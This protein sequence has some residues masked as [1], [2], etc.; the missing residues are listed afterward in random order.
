MTSS[1]NRVSVGVEGFDEI[2]DGG[3]FAEQSYLVRGS[4]GA[5]K[6]TFGLHFLSEGVTRDEDVLYIN[7][8]EG[9]ATIE[10]A[11][12]NF[13]FP[14]EEIDILD[15]A[16]TGDEFV[17]EEGYDIF[18][19]AEVERKPLTDEIAEAVSGA[20]P[21]RVFVDPVTQL[22]YLTP[23]EYQFRK[24][25]LSLLRFL[26][27][28]GATVLFTSQSTATEPDDDLQFM[29]DG[30][31][32]LDQDGQQRS[33]E[34][35]KF[36]GSDYAAGTHSMAIAGDGI[37]VYPVLPLTQRESCLETDVDQLSAGIP[38][39]D[40][41]LGG[42]IERGTTT[43]IS[44]PTGVGKSTLGTVFMKEAAGQGE[45]SKLYLFE[46]SVG[47]VVRRSQAVNIP[48][49]E[50]RDRGTLDIE[51]METLAID[52]TQFAAQVKADVQTHD[53]DIVMIDGIEG[54]KLA[55]HQEDLLKP[56]HRL[57]RYLSN[58]GVTT[59]LLSETKDITG[60]FQVSEYGGTYLADNLV[61]LQHLELHGEMRK[62]IGVLKKRMSNYERTLREFRITEHG[63]RVGEP[64]TDLRGVLTGTPELTTEGGTTQLMDDR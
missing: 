45:R 60:E 36:R 41:L 32:T 49:E 52:S 31:V 48:I 40:R 62:A 51:P 15:L 35:T 61:F 11:A 46:E 3:L 55:V 1:K 43:F 10:R 53:T 39:L 56:L 30:I 59:L 6:S 5:G 9:K 26:T 29:S 42:G 44:G 12:S 18:S 24:Q 28:N 13:G 63:L 20:A 54:Y 8:G 21:D 4:P 37:E 23:D 38:E 7:L 47:S 14:F 58:Q 22:R 16:P 27:E 17:E 25:I 64:M 57:V 33:I 50:M 2:V 34:V 19:S